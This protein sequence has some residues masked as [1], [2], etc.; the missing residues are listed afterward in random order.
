LK[1]KGWWVY[2][3]IHCILLHSLISYLASWG[4]GFSMRPPFSWS[5]LS[6]SCIPFF[7]FVTKVGKGNKLE[8]DGILIHHLV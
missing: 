7:D 3:S 1:Q 2:L 5:V 4:L 6:L 8:P